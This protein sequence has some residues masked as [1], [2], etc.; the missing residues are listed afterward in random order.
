MSQAVGSSLSLLCPAQQHEDRGENILCSSSWEAAGVEQE[1]QL[2]SGSP[3][4]PR[5]QARKWMLS[6]YVFCLIRCMRRGV[7]V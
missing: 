6:I 7:A 4:P 3:D 5:E 2:L 1:M